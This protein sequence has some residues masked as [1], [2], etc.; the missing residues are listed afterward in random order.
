MYL[1]IKL[2]NVCEIN[3]LVFTPYEGT[4]SNFFET[5][6]KGHDQDFSLNCFISLKIAALLN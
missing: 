6:H 2:L 3:K 5:T 1:L 4:E